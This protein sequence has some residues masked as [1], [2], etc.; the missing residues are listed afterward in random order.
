[1]SG[2]LAVVT[3]FVAAA[4][5]AGDRPEILQPAS[6]RISNGDYIWAR[7]AAEKGPVQ[8]VIS[9][10]NQKMYVYR[11]GKLIGIS[12]VST[13]K[14]SKRTPTGEFTI[15]QKNVYHRSNIYSN[16]PMPYMQ[17]LTWSGIAIH[18]GHLP[19]YAAS[20][21]CIRLPKAFA[22]Q[23]YSMTKLGATVLVTDQKMPD[24]SEPQDTAPLLVAKASDYQSARFNVVTMDD[25]AYA[26]PGE[27]VFGPTRAVVQAT[28]SQ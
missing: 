19:G 11:D 15:L 1:M 6:V 21:G 25:T 12:S 8:I 2:L 5:V 24:G 3:L 9:L 7:D 16:A 17:R 18:A 10:P 4:A 20:H 22:K 13:G 27:T 28:F 14:P 23:L 26:A